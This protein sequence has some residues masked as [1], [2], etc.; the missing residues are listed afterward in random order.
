MNI[1]KS[2]LALMKNSSGNLFLALNILCKTASPPPADVKKLLL[3]KSRKYSNVT[4]IIVV[5]IIIIFVVVVV[6][7]C[8]SFSE[9]AVHIFK[10]III[11]GTTYCN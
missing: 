1:Y 4:I 2:V 9:D 6:K 3:L 10:I 7:N 8:I 11:I 5:I